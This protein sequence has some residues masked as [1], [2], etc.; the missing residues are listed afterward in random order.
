[1]IV[2]LNILFSIIVGGLILSSSASAQFSAN[3]HL[4]RWLLKKPVIDSIII[5]G[6]KYF[7][8]SKVRGVMFSR[9]GNIFRAIKS[10]RR[11]RVQRET[12]MR[13]TAEVKYL[14]LSSGF[15]GVRLKEEF[16]PIPPDSNAK[17]I[18]NINEGRQFFYDRSVVTGTYDTTFARDLG[19][20][21]LR[22]KKG[23]PVNPFALKQTLYD[24]KSVLANR[25][26]P[27][28]TADYQ[29]D[30]SETNDRADIRFIIRSDSLVHFGNL[31]IIGVKY[32]DSSIVRREI[33][34][35]KGDIYRRKDIIDTQKRLLS[36]GY[37][38]TLQLFSAT[39]D[40]VKA[41]NR[42]NPDFVL[43]L[44]ERKPR[45]V[46]I[47]TGAGQDPYKDLIWDFSA[48]WGKRNFLKS[49]NLE[50][51]AQTR[52]VIFTEWRVISHG[53]SVKFTEPRFLGI[54]MPAVLTGQIEPG[55]RS[56]VQ[57]YRIQTWSV[58]LETNW[59]Y[60]ERLKIMSGT[61]YKSVNIYG[62]S[63]ADALKLR[64]DQGINIRRNIYF[65]INRDYRDNPFVP[66]AGS[67]TSL[68]LEYAGGIMGGDENFIYA[69]AS[70]SRYQHIWPGWISASRIK[71]GRVQ[72][73]STSANVP[74]DVRFYAGGANTV[75]GFPE[76][77]LGP[78]LPDGTPEGGNY[79]VIG[80]QEFRYPIIGKLWGSLFADMGNVFLAA[81]DIKWTNLAWSYGV[82]I[83]FISPAGP[84]RFD[85][86]RRIRTKTILPGHRFHFTILYA[87]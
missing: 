23:K 53:Y 52:L 8:E 73:F 85:Y 50:L 45:Y 84:I 27:Y 22:F 10:E 12:V 78:A 30:T 63:A 68:R 2:R 60:D 81:Q 39:G 17:V 44:K 31:R 71:F 16:E 77:G 24:C 75:R 21:A 43:N 80:N 33:T 40:S 38:L 13:D 76:N 1:M 7:D 6:N 25:G 55:V 79:L 49:R 58:S 46:S 28:A 42:L 86:A 72:A 19:G 36:T 3:S 56:A 14:Y 54:R 47:K 61:S 37:Y 9:R 26:Y 32:Y 48:S 5:K 41:A 29:I 57:P 51:S 59:N 67:L 69:D 70:W 66:A 82:G 20:I 11:G 87:F 35:H 34:F 74:I 4:N 83:Q 65:N 64:Q 62:L 18:M 15:L